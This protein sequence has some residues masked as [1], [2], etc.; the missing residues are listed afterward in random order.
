MEF[1][2][3]LGDVQAAGHFLIGQVL[4]QAIEHFLFPSAELVR[5]IAAQAASASMPRSVEKCAL[6]MGFERGKDPAGLAAMHYFMRPRK[7]LEGKPVWGEDPVRFQALVKYCQE[8]TA[9]ER[10]LR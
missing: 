7:W 1:N 9:I 5:G 10:R 8:D 3:A 2:G 4:K 6:A